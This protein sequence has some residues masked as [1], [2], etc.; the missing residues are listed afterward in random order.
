MQSPSSSAQT[1]TKTLSELPQLST[2]PAEPL[3]VGVGAVDVPE[4]AALTERVPGA[5]P[6]DSGYNDS[7][8]R[9]RGPNSDALDAK[10]QKDVT[11]IRKAFERQ[12]WLA[13]QAEAA[14]RMSS[15]A[16]TAATYAAYG[17]RSSLA[18]MP[19]MQS[20]A[21]AP[22]YRPELDQSY[23]VTPGFGRLEPVDLYFAILGKAV[24]QVEVDQALIGHASLSGHAFEVVHNIGRQ[25]HGD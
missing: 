16:Q 20:S 22:S 13:A 7:A 8:A 1:G 17:G 12:Q 2:T 9:A 4:I 25:P 15:P 6:A 11:A 18:N 3:A 21:A 10:L 5:A 24:A 14:S 23:Y 19:S